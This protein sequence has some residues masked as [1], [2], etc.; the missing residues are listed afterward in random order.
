[1]V[2]TRGQALSSLFKK[3]HIT[4]YP[5]NTPKYHLMVRYSFGLEPHPP[6]LIWNYL[7]VHWCLNL[8]QTGISCCNY[9]L[10]YLLYIILRCATY[11][12]LCF[13][14]NHVLLFIC[15]YL[16]TNNFILRPLSI[17]NIKKKLCLQTLAD[18]F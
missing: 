8:H 6:I 17:I 5:K 16:S 1:M 11:V 9:L 13:V 3:V 18:K 10:L 12:L 2:L 7:S 15:N 14:N 4:K